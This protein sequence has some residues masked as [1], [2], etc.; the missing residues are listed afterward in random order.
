LRN[1]TVRLIKKLR[2]GGSEA[3]E[4]TG[5]NLQ[6]DQLK[7]GQPG[8]LTTASSLKITGPANDL[9]EARST[10]N[11]EFV[12]GADLWPR[13]L[14]A[15]VE[16]ETLRSEGRL[17]ELAGVRAVFTADITPTEV[18][19]FSQ[20]FLRGEQL[21]G[22]FKMTGPLDMSKKEGHLK[23]EAAAIDRRVLN[24]FGAPFALDFG[25]TTLNSTTEVS[26]TDSVITANTRLSAA[27]FSVTQNGQTTL[28]I[29]LQLTYGMILNTANETATVQ[30]F[31]LEG[32]Q[33]QK[34]FL[35]GSLAAPMTLS[36]GKSAAA[37]SDS[38]FELAVTDFDFSAWKWFFGET[39][40]AGRLSLRLNLVSRHRGTDLKFLVTARIMDLAAQ[41]GSQ[42]LTEA[43]L[44]V[45]LNGE[46]TNFTKFTL[47]DY[48]IDLIEQAQPALSISGSGSYESGAFFLKSEIETAPARLM[49]S[50]PAT[51]LSFGTEMDGSF[52]NQGIDLRQGRLILAPTPR[53]PAN[54]LK[55]AGRLD[56]ANPAMLKANLTAKAETLDLTPLY[57]AF[58]GEKNFAAT[59]AAPSLAPPGAAGNVEPDPVPLP[60]QVS[61]EANLGEVYLR[62]IAVSNWQ[63][64]LKLDGGKVGLD[65]CRLTLNGAPVNASVHL[66]LGVKGYAYTLSLAMDHVPMEPIANSFSPDTRGQYQGMILASANIKGAGITGLSLR[67][68]LDGLASFTLTNANLQLIGPKAKK[69]IVPIAT[70][71]GLSEIAQAPVNWV[72]AQAEFAGGN[73]KLNQ[74]TLQSAA[75]QARAKGVIPINQV[76]TN[77]PLNLPIEFYLRRSQVEELGLLPPDTPTNASYAMLPGFATVIGTIGNPKTDLNRRALGGLLLQSGTGISK[78]LGASI[79][80]KTSGWIKGLENVFAGRKSQD[81][82]QS[83]TNAPSR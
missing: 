62:E 53:A 70:L 77:S 40:S 66:D 28:P 39:I 83:A 19:E 74:F 30:D 15:K 68:N 7:N 49:G 44:A 1:A 65:P 5:V 32:T 46:A 78:H 57:D 75:F 41:L 72:D 47:S 69:L 43:D 14:K 17:R 63:S 31:T 55:L 9:L 20:R 21:L 80:Q 64:T 58:A 51:P 10:G 50:G 73:I 45:K 13:S 38:T 60:L 67:K 6:L 79:G 76:L 33:K 29:D 54:E 2:D 27:Q 11:I 3:R 16:T 61:V 18:R 71:L 59:P 37:E 36:W 22:E 81:T 12:L 8:K 23:L 24:L 35:R 42:T 48:H 82:N 34:S 25:A 52:A 4:L 56:F 26:L